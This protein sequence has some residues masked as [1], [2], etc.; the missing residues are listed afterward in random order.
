MA[1]GKRGQPPK[2]EP[3]SRWHPGNEGIPVS[4]VESNVDKLSGARKP[5]TTAHVSASERDLWLEDEHR[6]ILEEAESYGEELHECI[7]A[8]HTAP[9]LERRFERSLAVLLPVLGC[10]L[11]RRLRGASS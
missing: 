4:A 7:R 6:Q 3:S 5:A 11:G 2:K 10:Y 8:G 1:R 9:D